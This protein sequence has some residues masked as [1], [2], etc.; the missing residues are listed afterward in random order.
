MPFRDPGGCLAGIAGL[1]RVMVD[2]RD[3]DAGL[4]GRGALGSEHLVGT[5][6]D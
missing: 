3:G 2:H 1:D 5:A 6:R 4:P